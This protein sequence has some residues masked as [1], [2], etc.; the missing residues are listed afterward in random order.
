MMNTENN[1]LKE[2]VQIILKGVD[3]GSTK[4]EIENKIKDA[5]IKGKELRVKLGLDPSAPDIH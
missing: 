1:V 3:S 4:D 2:A 5:K